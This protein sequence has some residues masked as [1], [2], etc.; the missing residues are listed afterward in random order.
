MFH[1]MLINSDFAVLYLGS[2]AHEYMMVR[3]SECIYNNYVTILY[4]HS[5]ELLYRIEAR[6]YL[7]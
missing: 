4:Q 3:Q 7:L 6:I 5:G 2:T 1:C